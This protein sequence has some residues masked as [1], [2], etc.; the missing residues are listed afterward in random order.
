VLVLTTNLPFKPWSTVFPGAACVSAMIDR[1]VHHYRRHRRRLLAAEGVAR[2]D[3]RAIEAEGRAEAGSPVSQEA[4]S[5][6]NT[7]RVRT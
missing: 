3:R 7:L 6:P 1:F 5:V 2:N 4:L